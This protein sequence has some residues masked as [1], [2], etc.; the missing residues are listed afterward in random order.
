MLLLGWNV[1]Y[2]INV[3]HVALGALRGECF[4]K[5][6]KGG[7]QETG[8]SLHFVFIILHFMNSASLCLNFEIALE[9]QKKNPVQT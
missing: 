2:L 4:V 9:I 3:R 1:I 6:G 5:C 8:E 7:A